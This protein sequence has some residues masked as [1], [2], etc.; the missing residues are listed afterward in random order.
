MAAEML[1]GVGE[2]GKSR[3]VTVAWMSGTWNKGRG[4][5]S[6]DEWNLD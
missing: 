2:S 4:Y 1:I 6:V 3:G 5:R